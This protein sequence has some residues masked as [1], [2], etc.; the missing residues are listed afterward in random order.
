LIDKLALVVADMPKMLDRAKIATPCVQQLLDSRLGPWTG[1]KKRQLPVPELSLEYPGP[2]TVAESGIPGS[3]SIGALLNA[4]ELIAASRQDEALDQHRKRRRFNSL[5][6]SNEDRG[7]IVT[8][9]NL[10]GVDLQA[11]IV[12]LNSSISQ[13]PGGPISDQGG[14]IDET[15]RDGNFG[16]PNAQDDDE[17]VEVSE[18]AMMAEVDK[19][20]T[21]LGGYM[22]NGMN[23]TSRRKGEKDRGMTSFTDTVR[24]HFA[25]H[26]GEDF[27]LEVWVCSSIGKA[28][29]Q[30]KRRSIEDLGS[31]LGDY[32]FGALKASN[33]RKEEE[34]KGVTDRTDAIDVSFP[35]GDDGSDCKV[36]VMLD[37]GTGRDVYENIFPCVK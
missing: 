23:M 28:I 30:T 37:F 2:D 11:E 1:S 10:E 20:G 35:N 15:T 9:E 22:F 17:E 12:P 29:L 13:L 8:V 26:E 27:K 18:I 16:V 21:A 4:A 32:L 31:M 7:S 24:L 14:M 36:E 25:Y 6:P 3:N 19:L 33:G 5:P 34:R